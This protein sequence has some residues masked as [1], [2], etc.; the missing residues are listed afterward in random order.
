MTAKQFVDAIQSKEFRAPFTPREPDLCA[1]MDA[2]G[3]TVAEFATPEACRRFVRAG[4]REIHRR[5]LAG[6]VYRG[7]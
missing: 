6:E 2:D 4:S 1:V 7:R 5:I 3:K